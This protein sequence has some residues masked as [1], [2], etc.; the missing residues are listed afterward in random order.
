M[1]AAIRPP[2]LDAV[3]AAPGGVLEDLHFVRGG[4]AFEVFS[5]IGKIRGLAGTYIF[6]GVRERH[7]ATSVMVA[8][9]LAVGSYVD[10]L[11]PGALFNEGVKQT[12][13]KALSIVEQLCE[14]HAARNRTIVEEQIDGPAGGQTEPVDHRGIDLFIRNFPP[15]PTADFPY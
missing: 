10:Q 13:G 8:V 14:S 9:C 5:V 7:F 12:L 3:N 2:A 4:M 11:G 15:F 1:T 6:Q